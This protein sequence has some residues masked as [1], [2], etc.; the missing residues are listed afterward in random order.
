[1]RYLG[2]VVVYAT[3]SGTPSLAIPVGTQLAE[4]HESRWPRSGHR[5]LGERPGA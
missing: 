3:Y 1:M 4:L 2:Q 5:V